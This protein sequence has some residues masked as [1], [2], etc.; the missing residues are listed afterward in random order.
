MDSEELASLGEMRIQLRESVKVR[1]RNEMLKLLPFSL[2]HCDP[3]FLQ[4]ILQ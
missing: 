1:S 2:Q 3:T 4:Y